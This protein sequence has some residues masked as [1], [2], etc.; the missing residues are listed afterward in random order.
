MYMFILDTLR[1]VKAKRI[2]SMYKIS[3]EEMRTSVTNTSLSLFYGER[4]IIQCVRSGDYTS[5]VVLYIQIGVGTRPH[6]HKLLSDS[7]YRDLHISI[8]IREFN[9]RKQTFPSIDQLEQLSLSHQDP[10]PF[11]LYFTNM[12]LQ[13]YID[14][15]FS[16]LDW[17]TIRQLTPFSADVAKQYVDIACTCVMRYMNRAGQSHV[18]QNLLTCLYLVLGFYEN[19]A[20][21]T[22]ITPRLFASIIGCEPRA[23]LKHTIHVF[24]A[25]DFR[26]NV[27]NP[28]DGLDI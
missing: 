27:L 26:L 17:I 9:I 11:Q 8:G 20:C 12:S 10:V 24:K 1:S 28:V 13:A 3:F 18:R 16:V 25:L 2:R 23:F 7:Y 19:E 21:L 6:F 14:H 15:V 22:G 4:K 5:P